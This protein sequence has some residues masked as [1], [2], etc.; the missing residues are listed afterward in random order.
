MAPV[1]LPPAFQFSQ[2]SLQDY[3]DCARRFQLRYLMQQQWPAPPAEP[4]HD[5]E[6]A[7]ILGKRFHLLVERYW[8]GLPVDRNNLDAALMPWWDAFIQ[9]P[10]PNL[11]GEIRKP[12]I[13]TSALVH[14]QRLV[15]TFD[16]LAY[17]PQG[18]VT[19]VDW[20][21]SQHRPTRSWLDHRL[22]TIV[23]PLL[24]VDSAPRLLGYTIKPE[25]V[26][27]IY[28]FANDPSNVETFQYSTVRYE[29]DKATIGVVLDRLMAT[30]G[31]IWPL[32]PDTRLC[33]LCQYRSLCDRG[34]EAGSVDEMDTDDLTLTES[35]EQ[36]IVAPDDFVL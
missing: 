9:T 11:P 22:Q 25:Q 31:E 12:E 14:G 23:Y 33:S 34:R 35:A 8:R 17:G 4:L 28:W 19:I 1:T 7:D 18:Q 16:L 5:A 6:R 3:S 15:A 10:P 20:K 36:Y 27:L 26:R 24:L 13:R 2:S 32:T 21:T 29:Q 30:D